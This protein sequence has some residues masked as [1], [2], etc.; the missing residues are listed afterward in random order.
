M[1]APRQNAIKFFSAPSTGHGTGCLPEP[2]GTADLCH[3][4]VLARG[5]RD[6]ANF[7]ER[8]S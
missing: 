1:A 5:M 2:R 7:A 3:H 8:V 6:C 4:V